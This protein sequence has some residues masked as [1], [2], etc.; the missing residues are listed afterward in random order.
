M[1]QDGVRPADGGDAVRFP[2][3]FPPE[4]LQALVGSER[5]SLIFLAGF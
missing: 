5:A 1:S 4:V 3:E 2:D